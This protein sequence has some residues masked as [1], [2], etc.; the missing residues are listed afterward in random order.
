MKRNVKWCEF[1]M[2]NKL[3][4]IWPWFT[5]LS[6]G[7]TIILS[8]LIK[9]GLN[10]IILA[11]LEHRWS[12]YWHKII[13]LQ[14]C[15]SRDLSLTH[16]RIF[17]GQNDHST[18]I[19]HKLYDLLLALK[20]QSFFRWFYFKRSLACANDRE[21][22]RQDRCFFFRYFSIFRFCRNLVW[23]QP[24]KLNNFCSFFQTF[25]LYRNKT[26]PTIYFYNLNFD[27]LLLKQFWHFWLPFFN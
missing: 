8:S 7:E 6:N 18:I 2:S 12:L 9:D 21:S 14:S 10:L 24:L 20:K 3:W 23:I 15:D 19:R 22:S 17:I 11:Y 1:L 26:Y 27:W 13:Y 25:L 5:I 4:V 16:T